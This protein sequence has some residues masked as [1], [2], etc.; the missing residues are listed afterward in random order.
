MHTGPDK[1]HMEKS[2]Q[3]FEQSKYKMQ[4]LNFFVVQQ[5]L[6]WNTVMQIGKGAA[7]MGER[8]GLDTAWLRTSPT[9]CQSFDSQSSSLTFLSLCSFTVFRE[10]R[11]GKQLGRIEAF[12]ILNTGPFSAT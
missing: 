4:R 7:I 5:S 9:L 6:E 2:R 8:Y 12:L 11:G 1:T 10:I 3:T